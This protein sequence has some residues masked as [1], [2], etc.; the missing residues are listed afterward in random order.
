MPPLSLIHIFLDGL[1]GMNDDIAAAL[2]LRKRPLAVNAAQG[3]LSIQAAAGL[4]SFDLLFFGRGGAHG[5]I[6]QAA[7]ARLKKQRHIQYLSLIHI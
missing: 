7:Q 2:L 1:V 4:E 3:L 5:H 6:C